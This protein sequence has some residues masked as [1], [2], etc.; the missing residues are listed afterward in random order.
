MRKHNYLVISDPHFHGYKAHSSVEGGINTRLKDIGRA[1]M[2][3]LHVGIENE[4]K[5]LLIPG[6]VFHVRGTLKVSTLNYVTALFK[7]A[8]KYMDVVLISGN[9]DFETIDGV[10]A[11]VSISNLKHENGNA[12]Y[13]L[14]EGKIYHNG[15][16]SDLIVG[17]PYC[18]DI[19]EFKSKAKSAMLERFSVVLCHQ[20]INE[21]RPSAMIP[22]TGLSV[23]EELFDTPDT[24]FLCGHFHNHSQLKNVISPGALV[25]HNFG[26]IDQDRGCIVL[27]AS[28][29]FD[30]YRL[31]A[32]V[33]KTVKSES[34]LKDVSAYIGNIVRVNTDDMAFA[35]KAIATLKPIAKTVEVVLQKKF[36]PAHTKAIKLGS[37][38]DML[39]Q[40]LNIA[41]EE[42]KE[43]EDLYSYYTENFK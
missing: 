28:G 30:F 8:L 15:E 20:G 29:G 37:V 1:F 23:A 3:A 19:A 36:T 7:L 6:D 21:F 22:K 10:S 32:P 5:A 43:R 41:I 16:G 4:C 42:V 18:H 34:D 27:K 25:Q 26:D 14:D 9:H 12:V 13:L 33:F 39:S 40:Y 38:E 31:D 35:E 17:I 2:Q 24:V 11:L